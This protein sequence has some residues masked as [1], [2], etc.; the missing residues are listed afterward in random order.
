[1]AEKLL[2]T[3]TVSGSASGTVTAM[4]LVEVDCT[5]T[6]TLL[7]SLGPVD[8]TNPAS[9]FSAPIS[10]TWSYSIERT[11]TVDAFPYGSPETTLP[12]ETFTGGGTISGFYNDE[13]FELTSG[14]LDV[15]SGSFSLGTLSGPT[16]SLH[17]SI[18]VGP[19]SVSVSGTDAT[20]QLPPVVMFANSLH[21]DEGAGTVLLTLSR[22]FARDVP[23]MVRVRTSSSI[24]ATEG[25]DFAAYDQILIFSGDQTTLTVPIAINEDTTAEANELITVTV[26]PGLY[27]AVNALS[28]T[29]ITIVDNDGNVSGT[30]SAGADSLN[31]TGGGDTL[32]GLDGND[33]IRGEDGSDKL[34]GDAGTDRLFGGNGDDTLQGGDGSDSLSGGDGNDRLDGG[35][36]ADSMAGGSGDDTYDVNHA[37]DSITESSGGGADLVRSSVTYT[38]PE[39]VEML[40]LGVLSGS[41]NG[42]GN[43]AANILLGNGGNNSLVGL[44][45]NDHLDGLGGNDSLLGGV[46][47]DGLHGNSGA[48]LLSGGAG[49]DTVD[50]GP[51]ADRLAGGTGRDRFIFDSSLATRDVIADFEHG[52]DRICL[53]DDI[54]RRLGQGGTRSLASASFRLGASQDANDFILYNRSSGVLSY[55]ADGNGPGAAVAIAVLGSGATHPILSATDILVIN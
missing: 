9:V 26:E 33:T 25:V 1:M 51:G 23:T 4:G 31:G 53:D 10:G 7:I 24:T 20:G 11:G 47:A 19:L 32:A 38:L 55:D 42:T 49:N 54:F 43:G 8:E 17:G 36:D 44:G 2:L 15:D 41:I 13:R 40:F 30:P 48:D 37:G 39:N 22:S 12:A 3:G 21:V 6:F 16:G 5:G 52:I 28:Q 45:G 50:G 29:T 18:D 46:G 14:T 35:G 34:S 27:A